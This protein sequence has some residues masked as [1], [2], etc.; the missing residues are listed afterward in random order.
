ML[1]AARISD[2]VGSSLAGLAGGLLMPSAAAMVGWQQAAQAPT[3]D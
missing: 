2:T 3:A 1:A